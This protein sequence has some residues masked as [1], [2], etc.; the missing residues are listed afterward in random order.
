MF[1]QLHEFIKENYEQENFNTTYNK[2]SKGWEK[3]N[4]TTCQHICSD[5]QL[6]YQQA[7]YDYQAHHFFYHYPAK[8][9]SLLNRITRGRISE[10][11]NYICGYND[12]KATILHR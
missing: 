5:Y 7:K 2:A 12:A 4:Y 9:V 1:R 6:G 8:I 10:I 11:E 3:D